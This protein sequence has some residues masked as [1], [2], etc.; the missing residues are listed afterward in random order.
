MVLHVTGVELET[1]R[2]K[3][4]NEV[5]ERAVPYTT[6]LFL[7][8]IR[9]TWNIDQY[10]KWQWLGPYTSHDENIF[11]NLRIY[12][13]I[14]LGDPRFFDETKEEHILSTTGRQ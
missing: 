10:V 2:N 9:V 7:D 3:S 5:S 12:P 11:Y 4:V 8:F 1:T 14:F 6:P 13:A